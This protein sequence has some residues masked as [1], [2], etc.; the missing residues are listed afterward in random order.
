MKISAVVLGTD[1]YGS[2]RD[3]KVCFDIMD[4]YKELGGNCIDTAKIYSNGSSE[5]VIGRWLK[6][7]GRSDMYISTKGAHPLSDMS[8]SRLSEK[9]IEEDLNSS[10]KRLS[11][12]YIDLYWLH[13]D[14]EKKPVE[15]IIEALN[16]FIKQGKI[17]HIGASNWT[18][19][20][21]NEASDYAQK[22]NLEAFCASQIKWSL[23]VTSPLYNDDKTLV[24]MNGKE[25]EAYLKNKIA[26]FAYASQGKGFFSK[27]ASGKENLSEKAKSRYLCETNIKRCEAI[28]RLAE[29]KA[30]SISQA[31]ISYIYSNKDIN[32]YAIIGPKNLKQLNDCMRKDILL[33]EEEFQEL[34]SII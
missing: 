10:L 26:V 11:L 28:K 25:Y 5:A 22:H 6:Q 14:D 4:A 16:K 19:K 34:N 9:E 20:R 29:E 8:I 2:E 12:D 27:Y 18:A 7:R 24:E 13:R 30:V 1:Y 23:A 31:V 15:E 21:I 32:A 33:T 3:E 17:R